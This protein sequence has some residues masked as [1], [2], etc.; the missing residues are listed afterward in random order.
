MPPLSNRLGRPSRGIP[1]RLD[2]PLHL[3]GHQLLEALGDGAAI[4]SALKG[5]GLVPGTT[6]AQRGVVADFF[7]LARH[8]NGS[9]NNIRIVTRYR[10]DDRFCV[11]GRSCRGLSPGALSRLGGLRDHD[12]C[13]RGV[14]E[15]APPAFVGLVRIDQEQGGTEGVCLS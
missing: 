13:W 8:Y 15:L 14:P 11:A 6:C 7:Q 3:D 9:R 12:Q 5:D 10:R 4:C 1:D 2:G